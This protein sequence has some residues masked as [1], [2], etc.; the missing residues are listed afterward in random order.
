[1]QENDCNG[2]QWNVMWVNGKWKLKET[3]LRKDGMSR[4][5][6]K[7]LWIKYGVDMKEK[8]KKDGDN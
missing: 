7:L 4:G 6:E 1:M 2:G 5:N 3:V 8:G